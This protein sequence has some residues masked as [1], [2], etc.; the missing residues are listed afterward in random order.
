MNKLRKFFS[1]VPN[2]NPLDRRIRGVVGLL[3][4]ITSPLGTDLLQGGVVAWFL[5]I[6]GVLNVLAALTNWCWMYAVIG[7]NSDDSTESDTSQGSLLEDIKLG[8]LRTK[9][10]VAFGTIVLSLSV[11]YTIEAI[12]AATKT[13]SLA[14]ALSLH[15]VSLLVAEEVSDELDGELGKEAPIASLISEKQL[16][17]TL[18][19]FEDSFVIYL[20]DGK[21]WVKGSKRL[22]STL[23]QQ[24]FKELDYVIETEAQAQ[25]IS[26]ASHPNRHHLS[27][28]ADGELPITTIKIGGDTFIA[29]HHMLVHP[30]FGS[31]KLVL[32]RQSN[33]NDSAVDSVLNRLVYSSFI[34][35]WLSIW[36]AV[37]VVYFVW[38]YV[39]AANNRVYAY[40]KTDQR[41]GLAN[42]IAL[43][44]VMR[45]E[46]IFN[47]TQ[48]LS[49]LAAFPR[50]LV[51]LEADK[52]LDEVNS[53]LR[54]VGSRLKEIV[55]QD[56]YVAS[57][58]DG[59]VVIV[60]P[61]E[62]TLVLQTFRLILGDTYRIGD[63]LV[64]LEPTFVSVS[65]PMDVADFDGMRSAVSRLMRQAIRTGV[66]L[67][68][69][70]HFLMQT[71]VQTKDYPG[72]LRAAL[73]N[74]ELELY[75]QPKVNMATG[76]V[77]GAEALVRW[78]HPKEG[79]LS[80]GAFLEIL[81]NSNMRT[82]FACFVINEAADIANTL[83][84]QGFAVP[85]SFNLSAGDFFDEKVQQTLSDVAEKYSLRDIRS[86][87]IELTE[88]ETSIS[89]LRIQEA[90]KLVSWMGYKIALDDFGTGMSS[91]SYFQDMPISTLKIDKSFVDNL[92]PSSKNFKTL[93]LVHH[94]AVSFNYEVVVEGVET[95]AQ[96][97]LLTE[98][99]YS[100]AQGYHYQRPLPVADF[101][102][103][104]DS[105]C[106]NQ[107]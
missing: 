52:S 19:H 83:R 12:N 38:R 14:E 23:A 15:E 30:T 68:R 102:I 40:A 57:F 6:F 50:N 39:S 31:L 41:T 35:F 60:A 9:I 4:V 98:L 99:G 43:E 93:E 2:M 3:L 80:P 74:R 36:G 46:P 73:K 97:E 18:Y 20:G 100:L 49:I 42:E 26:S 16:V 54:R 56:H 105:R 66:P 22:S 25:L 69:H 61:E 78:N 64:N 28:L 10:A 7:L 71:S 58:H 63:S 81:L 47:H 76:T 86:L 13:A 101:I 89:S 107:P 51:N 103:Y 1:L 11:L 79:V 104:V 21:E 96:V 84:A 82:D 55:R 87:E 62:D 5:L 48:D 34:V 59:T 33:A 8:G 85:I 72:E 77:I 45:K 90:L 24:L 92:E 70:D 37:G 44:E 91:L 29:M 53:V 27:S 75:L 67:L 106:T 88:T 17:D 65:F 95:Q 32:A 94:L